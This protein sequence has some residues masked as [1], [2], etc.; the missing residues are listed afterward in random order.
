MKNEDINIDFNDKDLVI[1]K[2][3][4][5]ETAVVN[6]IKKYL[7]YYATQLKDEYIRLKDIIE[8]QNNYMISEIKKNNIQILNDSYKF[9]ELINC[10]N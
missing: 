3:L 1:N 8:K 5:R 6:E 7:I 2:I 10:K 4:P 9:L